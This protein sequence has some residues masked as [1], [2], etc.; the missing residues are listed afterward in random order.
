MPWIEDLPSGKYRACWR[1]SAGVKRSRS[2][3]TAA[4][5]ARRFAGEQES[6]ARA[7]K[8]TY[9]GRS[10]TWGRWLPQWLE[11]RTIEATTQSSD[12]ARLKRWV[13]PRWG[14]VPLA[15]ISPEDVQTWVNHELSRNMSP[16]S[17][18]KVYR[19]LSSSLKAAVRY[20]K[21][22]VS[23]CVDIELPTV[24][25]SDERFLTRGEVDA[26]LYH[27]DEPY[28]TAAILLVGT[29]MRFGEMAGLHWHRV[30]EMAK[31]LDVHET[32][33]GL[34]IKAYPKGRK[35]RRVPVPSWVFDALPERTGDQTCGLDH[36]RGT[37]CRSGLVVVG[38][39]GAPMRAN[40]MLR[41][42]WA[43]AMAK[44]GLDPAR[45]HDL[46]HSYASWLVQAGR[47]M[48]EIAEVLGHSETTV[49]ARY[50]HLAGTHMDAVRAVMDGMGPES[51]APYLPHRAVSGSVA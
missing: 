40:N 41:R 47:S 27:L 38:P 6:D 4:A 1:D 22:A 44:A 34:A 15:R 35:K 9:Q 17:V 19:L 43:P 23:P 11:L 26:V 7:G 49:T 36:A 18:A 31:A 45:Q 12:A 42:H 2:G 8:A 51:V 24:P 33:D 28:R 20:K 14:N 39:M 3:F 48:S 46:R 37:R 50:A 25:P 16:A 21:L 5:E 29:G 32:W 13:E 10:M 30:D